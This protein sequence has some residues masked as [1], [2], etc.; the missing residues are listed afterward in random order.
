MLKGLTVGFIEMGAKDNLTMTDMVSSINAYQM[1]HSLPSVK[2]IGLTI[3]GYDEDSRELWEIPEVVAYVV[4][5]VITA[6]LSSTDEK[7][8]DDTKSFVAACFQAA[9]DPNLIHLL[10]EVPQGSA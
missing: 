6:G 2:V 7:L 10:T 3:G 8:S 4:A 1:L 9:T 5:W